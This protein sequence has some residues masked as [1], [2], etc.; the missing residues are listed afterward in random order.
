MFSEIIPTFNCCIGSK[1]LKLS[2]ISTTQNNTLI[3]TLIRIRCNKNIKIIKFRICNTFIKE[4]L[5]L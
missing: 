2:D 4:F 1:Q 3:L 5:N